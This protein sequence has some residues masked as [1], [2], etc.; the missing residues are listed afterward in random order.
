MSMSL[1]V[2]GQRDG[3]I[4]ADAK[5]VQHGGRERVL[6]F[7]RH[8]RVPRVLVD[9]R[10]RRFVGWYAHDVR[11]VVRGADEKAVARPRRLYSCLKQR[12][13]LKPLAIER[14]VTN[15]AFAD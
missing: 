12:E 10:D 4:E 8:V 3:S 7:A 2:V 9:V 6:M 1:A 14:Q 15:L 13:L 5:L 11:T